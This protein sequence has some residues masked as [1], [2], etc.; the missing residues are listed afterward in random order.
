MLMSLQHEVHTLLADQIVKELLDDPVIH[1]TLDGTYRMVE[2]HDLP[3][4]LAD[5]K[6]LFEPHP[7][8]PEAPEILVRIQQEETG[9]APL[10]GEERIIVRSLKVIVRED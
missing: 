2:H 6:L 10:E 1:G 8:R 5:G 3:L 4:L 9:I 7:L